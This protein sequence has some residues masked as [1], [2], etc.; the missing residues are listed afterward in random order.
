[1]GPQIVIRITAEDVSASEFRRLRQRLSGVQRA[2]RDT[3]RSTS[4]ARGNLIDFADG[5]SIV[6]NFAATAARGVLALTTSIISAAGE[7]ESYIIAFTA[8]TG[9]V[10]RAT[11]EI[12]TLRQVARLP[13]VNFQQAIQGQITFTALGVAAQDAR[14]LIIELG[15]QVALVGGGPDAFN[16]LQRAFRQTISLGKL[17][18]EEL[19]QAREAS[20]LV[21]VA[22][23]EA[24]GTDNAERIAEQVGQGREA[25]INN[26]ILPITRAFQQQGRAAVDSFNN[27]L[28]NLSNS[29]FELRVALGEQFLPSA[30][31]LLQNLIKL[32]DFTADLNTAWGGLIGDFAAATTIVVTLTAA[33]TG[34][35]VIIGALNASLVSLFTTRFGR[36]AGGQQLGRLFGGG[37]IVSGLQ[38]FAGIATGA[39]IGGTALIFL[40]RH[41]IRTDEAFDKSRERVNQFNQALT[42]TD[43]VAGRST[44]LQQLIERIRDLQNE[45]DKLIKID[46]TKLREELREVFQEGFDFFRTPATEQARFLIVRYRETLDRI[47]GTDIGGRRNLPLNRFGIEDV[48]GPA[49]FGE[50]PGG[51][52]PAGQIDLY[53]LFRLTTDLER[54]LRFNAGR[55]IDFSTLLGGR[56]VSSLG[57]FLAES[58][59][60]IKGLE[61]RVTFIVSEALRL[62]AER[63][64]EFL[65]TVTPQSLQQEIDALRANRAEILRDVQNRRYAI[66]STGLLGPDPTGRRSGHDPYIEENRA[67]IDAASLAVDIL[68]QKIDN[69]NRILER[70]NEIQASAN[71][72]TRN[73]GLEIFNLGN[74]IEDITKLFDDASVNQNELVEAINT[75]LDLIVQKSQIELEEVN[76][77]L[78][79][80]QKNLQEA[81]DA[82]PPVIQRSAEQQKSID[83]LRAIVTKLAPEVELANARILREVT[84]GEDRLTTLYLTELDRRATALQDRIREI[85]E[86]TFTFMFDLIRRERQLRVDAIEDSIQQLVQAQRSLTNADQVRGSE[87]RIQAL[88]EQ[89][90]QLALDQ[91]NPDLSP[92]EQAIERAEITARFN[93]LIIANHRRTAEIIKQIYE[94]LNDE[95]EEEQQQLREIEVRR[96]ERADQAN[97]NRYQQELRAIQNRFREWGELRIG[98][99]ERISLA[100]TDIAVSTHERRNQI[101]AESERRQTKIRFDNRFASSALVNAL[102]LDEQERTNAELEQ[103]Y[104][105]AEDTYTTIVERGT[106]ERNRIREQRSQEYYDYYRELIQDERNLESTRL[107]LQQGQLTALR[108]QGT[109]FAQR[110]VFGFQDYLQNFRS[111]QAQLTEITR[112][113]IANLTDQ[114][115]TSEQAA[116]QRG[117]LNQQLDQQLSQ[118]VQTFTGTVDRLLSPLFSGA[119]DFGVLLADVFRNLDVEAQQELADLAEETQ[120]RIEQVR[121]DQTIGAQQQARRIERI[122]QQSAERR[123]QIEIDLNRAKRES[124][125]QFVQSFLQGVARQISAELQLRAVRSIT[126]AVLDLG[127]AAGLASSGPA[128][129]GLLAASAGLSFLSNL[130]FHNEANDMLA[131]QA[132]RASTQKLLRDN[133]ARLGRESAHD[134]VDNFQEGFEEQATTTRSGNYV[135]PGNTTFNMP[136]T[137]NDKTVQ[138]ISFTMDE[139]VQQGRL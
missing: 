20:P 115:I 102:I 64:I 132:G 72:T 79:E 126:S 117:L 122:E 48:F 11:E 55:E 93:T 36:V 75:G 33:L 38:R 135:V 95:L 6:A 49:I 139:L 68:S 61:E 103:L 85:S 129:A 34:L 100:E 10:G 104:Q 19:N 119:Q 47:A 127:L 17:L 41:L 29:F 106:T 27:S 110:G 71:V 31:A 37:G 69:Y 18:T 94:R 87:Q 124:F 1:M 30:T 22:L 138:E 77:P 89:Q 123:V 113:Q 108:N 83:E 137:I 74:Q 84:D 59:P 73:F 116:L 12:E 70:Y 43:T 105:Q 92:Q 60:Q 24:F 131:R 54:N 13:G 118:N 111:E 91:I 44:G 80:A 63:E 57:R 39:V 56:P 107:Q 86:Q 42:V 90:R 99:E 4:A 50:I 53:N 62:E 3:A 58:D 45:I 21:T 134:I 114:E 51:D 66:S 7:M 128:A 112:Q 14:D 46:K 130:S 26:F 125:E 8:L 25:I 40:L 28:Q 98:L 2:M 23:E 109:L 97:Q 9:S 5:L 78:L 65:R 32:L 16:R 52:I 96:F 136:I 133:A 81:I 88:I 82:A 101:I 120:R 35:V 121:N 67:R 15:N 76:K